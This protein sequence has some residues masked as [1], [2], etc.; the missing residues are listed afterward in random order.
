MIKEHHKRLLQQNPKE[1]RNSRSKSAKQNVTEIEH[2]KL[3]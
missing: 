2:G 1:E 3:D